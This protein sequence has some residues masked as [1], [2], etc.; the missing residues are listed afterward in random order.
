VHVR[1]WTTVPPF[2]TWISRGVKARLRLA[3]LALF[4]I[5]ALGSLLARPTPTT[6]DGK[7]SHFMRLGDDARCVLVRSL[8]VILA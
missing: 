3:V 7:G 6:Q 1:H 4:V 5:G 8:K 2:G